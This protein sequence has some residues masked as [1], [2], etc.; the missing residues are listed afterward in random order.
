V[1]FLPK[2]ER[3]LKN[4]QKVVRYLLLNVK[5][6]DAKPSELLQQRHNLDTA[7]KAQIRSGKVYQQPAEEA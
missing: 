6:L 2:F 3:T 1:D 4:D 5:E 7:Y